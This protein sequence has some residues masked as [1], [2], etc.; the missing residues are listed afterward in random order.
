MTPLRSSFADCVSVCLLVLC[1]MAAGCRDQPAKNN[2]STETQPAG[3]SSAEL[4]TDQE[5]FQQT[6]SQLA[7]GELE[8]AL[9]T[10]DQVLQRHPQQADALMLA[11]QIA[12]QLNRPAQAIAY[13]SRVEKQSE[14]FRQALV[15]KAELQRGSG[16]L[17]E[18]LESYQQL[19][20]DPAQKQ[21]ALSR[22]VMILTITGDEVRAKPYIEQLID[23][24]QF[25]L[26]VLAS[27]GLRQW[28][29]V[30]EGYLQECM[31]QAPDDAQVLLGLMRAA[32]REK[33]VKVFSQLQ[34]KVP[35]GLV[36]T[37][38]FLLL[39]GEWLLASD[40]AGFLQWA[41]QHQ[42]T[43]T[44][45]VSYWSLCGQLLERTGKVAQAVTCY[46]E[47]LRMNPWHRTSLYR[48]SSLLNAEANQTA[49]LLR[50]RADQ[51][52]KLE[53]L[54]TDVQPNPK[55]TKYLKQQA[56][57]WLQIGETK[58]AAA[59]VAL[60]RQHHPSLEW[61][62]PLLQRIRQQHQSGED[63]SHM[64]VKQLNG[65]P[66]TFF[67]MPEWESTVSSTTSPDSTAG[68]AEIH[69]VDIGSQV[70]L[71]WTYFEHND[72]TT[73]G[74]RLIETNGG[75]VGVID[76]NLDLYPDLYFTQ[77]SEWPPNQ[78]GTKHSDVLFWNRGGKQFEPL[79]AGALPQ[80]L[81]YSMGI[82][83]GDLDQDGFDDLAI[84]NLGRN[85]IF[86]N[87]GDGTFDLLP[88]QAYPD[89]GH[90]SSSLA[91]ADL[92][93]DGLPDIYEA[94]YAEQRGQPFD[95]NADVFTL[96]CQT[97]GHAAICTPKAFDGS[98]DRVMVNTGLARFENQTEALGFTAPDGKGLGVVIANLDGS[99]GV[100]LFVANDM[101]PNHYFVRGENG[102]YVND[103]IVSGLAVNAQGQTQACMGIALGDFNNDL[104]P[105]LHV[106]NFYQESNA[107]YVN[108]GAGAFDDQ[109]ESS[110]ISNAS[111]SLLGFG[112]Q[113][114]DVDCDGD[115]DLFI[116]NG[117]IDNFEYQGRPEKM[118]PLL[119]SNQQGRFQPFQAF[120]ANSYLAGKWIGRGMARV[121]YDRNLKAEMAI[122]HMGRPVALVENQ[123][124][125]STKQTLSIL[126]RGTHSPRLPVG[127]TLTVTDGRQT[128]ARY[129]TAGDGFQATNDAWH[130]ISFS[131]EDLGSPQDVTATVEWP[132]GKREEFSGLQF[133]SHWLLREGTG[134]A[135]EM[136]LPRSVH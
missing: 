91:I 85:Q 46:R 37:P 81:N 125:V 59:W 12:Q 27:Y 129:V 65:L 34:Q 23:L 38:P 87:N 1:L 88:Q 42:V 93:G 79:P 57:Q 11:A 13:Y 97:E 40:E 119:L 132:D 110:G 21:F 22:I 103:A 133:G 54:C 58:L 14:L 26:T 71:D 56:E 10:I 51:V 107:Y 55:N 109:A 106:T 136:P 113:S 77:G 100:E 48:L 30:N 120:E 108:L 126:L 63:S 127:A 33:D 36:A 18:A 32:L 96:I 99:P 111:Y 47:A 117:D 114:W 43:L 61:L 7:A 8:A 24:G 45:E 72:L 74:R 39:Q 41:K 2:V 98:Q 67:E 6:Q 76:F 35:D 131:S 75:G 134:N 31:E 5:L 128:M 73:P 44:S 17:A 115:L 20:S 28:A 95:A 130:A 124:A 94:N 62:N 82:A 112:T 16:R 78:Q 3:D 105:D 50:V 49:E 25:D 116:T 29:L 70:G 123:S 90:W 19:V 80:E 84:A 9:Q 66:E 64:L 104:R 60:A 69:L 86:L 102:S 92:N 135:L 53:S 4:L 83:V 68:Q 118:P 52:Q 89:L 122:S 101:E 121:D 15:A